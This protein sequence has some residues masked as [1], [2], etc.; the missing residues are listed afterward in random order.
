MQDFQTHQGWWY[1]WFLKQYIWTLNNIV[2][3]CSPNNLAWVIFSSDGRN[4]LQLLSILLC[5]IVPH[6]LVGFSQILFI[7]MA[8]HDLHTTLQ[9]SRLSRL[10]RPIINMIFSKIPGWRNMSQSWV[11]DSDNEAMS[12]M[13]SMNWVRQKFCLT[14]RKKGAIQWLYVNR[15]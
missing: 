9:M 10:S 7:I 2:I 11:S 3:L 13:E 8:F 15:H 12:E 4:L 5:M 14:G 1:L 6:F